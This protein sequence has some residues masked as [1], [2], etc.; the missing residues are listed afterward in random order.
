MNFIE[1]CFHTFHNYLILIYFFSV[2]LNR[3]LYI[4]FQI[5]HNKLFFHHLLLLLNYLHLEYNNFHLLRPCLH[6]VASDSFTP[7]NQEFKE[8]KNIPISV[9]LLHV[10]NYMN[11][12]KTNSKRRST[13]DQVSEKNKI[14]NKFLAEYATLDK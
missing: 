11:L 6:N 3:S 8:Y 5:Y 10:K 9:S 1:R 4:S 2:Y 12:I 14:N 13:S 7:L